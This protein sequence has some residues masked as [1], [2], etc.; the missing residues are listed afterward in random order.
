VENGDRG[1]RECLQEVLPILGSCS[2]LKL[3]EFSGIL[4][5]KG[6]A[7]VAIDT[8]LIALVREEPNGLEIRKLEISSSGPRLESVCFL[9]LP[10]L[11][12]DTT[13]EWMGASKEWVPTSRHYG[14]SRSLR[15]FHVP[16]YS[17]AVGTIAFDLEYDAPID[18]GQ[19][20]PIYRMVISVAGLLSAMHT[21]A[22]FIP[23]VEW[24]P[25]ITHL[26]PKARLTTAGP[27]WI[28][29]LSPLVIRD[30]GTRHALHSESTREDSSS[31]HSRPPVFDTHWEPNNIET[32]LPYRDLVANDLDFRQF[33]SVKADRE[34]I[35]GIINKVCD[36]VQITPLRV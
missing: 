34:W 21:R 14:R 18:L 15:G 28:T 31:V 26:F 23:W 22:R 30:Y 11:T 4:R 10:P 12:S 1:V 3:C 6:P 29:K 9:E 36:Y 19:R 8:S 25:A 17:S 20:F 32:H 5:Y 16:F 24:G 35:I 13:V 7:F 33:D 2:P 27:F